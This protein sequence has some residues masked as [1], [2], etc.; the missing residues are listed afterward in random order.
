MNTQVN[1]LIVNNRFEELFRNFTSNDPLWGSLQTICNDFL[2]NDLKG[3]IYSQ[4]RTAKKGEFVDPLIQLNSEGKIYPKGEAQAELGPRYFIDTPRNA[5]AYNERFDAMQT[6]HTN[7]DPRLINAAKDMALK[8]N[9]VTQDNV[10]SDLWWNLDQA[11]SYQKPIDEQMRL[12][13]AVYES[14]F[15]HIDDIIADPKNRIAP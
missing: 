3:M 13:D 10:W 6:Y 7:R 2:A 8:L 12:A 15:V 4:E 5:S 11:I 14:F 9:E 1:E